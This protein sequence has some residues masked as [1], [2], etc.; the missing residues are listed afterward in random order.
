MAS[1]VIMSRCIISEEDSFVKNNTDSYRE[2]RDRYRRV[3]Q[4]D[5]A[6]LW[7]QRLA[8]FSRPSLF[9]RIFWLIRFRL[10]FRSLYCFKVWRYS[11]RS[12]SI[13][14]SFRVYLPTGSIRPPEPRRHVGRSRSHCKAAAPVR[15]V[16]IILKFS[17]NVT[18]ISW[19]SR[20]S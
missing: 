6:L 17:I 14:R 1:Y 8:E 12:R 10:F 7:Q 9:G 3:D 4:K 20:L 2:G 19:L 11:R 5:G 13:S 15:T 18:L 16:G